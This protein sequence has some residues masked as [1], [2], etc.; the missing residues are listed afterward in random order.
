[1]VKKNKDMPRNKNLNIKQLFF[2]LII[3]ITSFFI[4]KKKKDNF[5][6][7]LKNNFNY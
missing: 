4:Q 2:P 6:F 3:R 1:M 7:I 5:I